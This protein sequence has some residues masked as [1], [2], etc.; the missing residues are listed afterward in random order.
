[1]RWVPL[2]L[3]SMLSKTTGRLGPKQIG[4]H[5]RGGYEERT[6]IGCVEG[7]KLG[8]R[9]GVEHQPRGFDPP[10]ELGAR[11]GACGER[12]QFERHYSSK[13]KQEES[14][15]RLTANCISRCRSAGESPGRDVMSRL[16]S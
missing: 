8:V 13:R 1:M 10:V 15:A 12:R 4:P 16:T 5:F 7:L 9:V 2:S 11:D 6:L 3:T 14:P